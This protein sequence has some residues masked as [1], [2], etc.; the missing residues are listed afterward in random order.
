MADTNIKWNTVNDEDITSLNEMDYGTD[1]DRID[2]TK[3]YTDID[4][5]YEIMLRQYNIPLSTPVEKL[6]QVSDRTYIF[7]D[8]VV[9]CLE[10]EIST[11]LIEK[12]AAV[13][14]TPAKFV[15]RDSAFNDDIELKDVSFRRLSSLIRTHQTEEERKSKYNN[16]VVE[17]I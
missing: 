1:K 5:V 11:E 14:P 10:P 8:A 2:F 3:G 6:P 17:F 9:V 16:Y 15:L 13:E 4:V 12:L 7:A